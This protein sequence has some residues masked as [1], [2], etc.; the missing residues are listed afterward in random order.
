MIVLLVAA[1]IA[2]SLVVYFWTSQGEVRNFKLEFDDYALKVITNFHHL[3]IMR[4]WAAYS[5]AAQFTANCQDNFGSEEKAW[6][7]V[8]MPDFHDQVRGLL[9]LAH[10]M[11][12]EFS[13]F[14]PNDNTIRSEWEAYATENEVS[15]NEVLCN[16]LRQILNY[17][18]H[19]ICSLCVG[20]CQICSGM[21]QT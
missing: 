3:A 5:V 12:I 10:S 14:F 21:G 11:N 20:C 16:P 4:Q 13:P 8:T 6:P 1:A 19:R 2:V 18:S 9:V 7:N 17:N 15:N